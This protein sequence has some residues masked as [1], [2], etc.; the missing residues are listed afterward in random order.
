MHVCVLHYPLDSVLDLKGLLKFFY[1]NLGWKLLYIK[2]YL[3][4]IPMSTLY[5]NYDMKE[6][7]K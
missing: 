7:A 5:C 6:N 1:L 3:I 2:T 4:V